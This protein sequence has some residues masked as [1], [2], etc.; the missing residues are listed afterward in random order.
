MTEEEKIKD[1]A[2][3]RV[4]IMLARAVYCRDCKNRDGDPCGNKDC[5][6][7][8]RQHELDTKGE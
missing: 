1:R 4:A 8:K 3:T 6:I 7:I 5:P 2:G